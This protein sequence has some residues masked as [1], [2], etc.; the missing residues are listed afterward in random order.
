MKSYAVNK[1]SGTVDIGTNMYCT[2]SIDDFEIDKKKNL[3][4]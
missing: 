1:I 3:I 2:S 4:I